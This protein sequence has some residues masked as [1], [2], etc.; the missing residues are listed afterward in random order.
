MDYEGNCD[1]LC[2]STKIME[3]IYFMTI[4]EVMLNPELTIDEVVKFGKED[5]VKDNPLK[6]QKLFEISNIDQIKSMFLSIDNKL[7]VHT[8]VNKRKFN[9][10]L[11]DFVFFCKGDVYEKFVE[12]KKNCKY[13]I[14]L[15][16]RTMQNIL[17]ENDVK[18]SIKRT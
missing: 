16:K 12:N 14:T 17:F 7:G 6:D 1:D 4:F 2:K 9:F 3:M 11:D 18:H 10:E 15:D 8:Q 5:R 13:I